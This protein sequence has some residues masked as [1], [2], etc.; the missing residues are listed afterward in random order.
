MVVDPGDPFGDYYAEIL[1]AEG[2]NEFA[3]ANVSSVTAQALASHEVVV[4]A[5]MSLSA[6]QVQMLSD[7]VAGG[8]RL[9]AMRPDAKLAPLLGVSPSGG[10]LS[11]G[12][13]RV[14]TSSDAGKGITGTTDA[15]PRPAPTS[16]TTPTVTRSRA[17]VR[18]PR[19]TPTR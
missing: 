8:G 9:I 14:D 16:S 2:L 7:W 3:V 1:R 10:S 12:Y 17:R 18:S 13:L 5:S 15:V 19:C 11:N 6:A 4:L